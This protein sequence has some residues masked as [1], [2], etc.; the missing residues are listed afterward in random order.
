MGKGEDERVATQ[1]TIWEDFNASFELLEQLSQTAT[2][3][4]ILPYYFYKSVCECGFQYA[5]SIR[6]SCFIV[7]VSTCHRCGVN[8]CFHA[9]GWCRLVGKLVVVISSYFSV[10][11]PYRKYWVGVTL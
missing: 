7:Q 9:A 10:N 1:L 2:F 11:D 3:K 6:C 4:S 8:D 5:P